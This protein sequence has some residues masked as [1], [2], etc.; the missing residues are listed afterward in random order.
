M[1]A[2]FLFVYQTDQHRLLLSEYG[3]TAILLDA[4]YNVCKHA[5]PFFQ[6]AVQTNRGYQVSE[7]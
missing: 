6:L 4:T 3:G 5:F 2:G 7:Q 1:V